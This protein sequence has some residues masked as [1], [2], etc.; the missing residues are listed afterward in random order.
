MTV[1]DSW[2]KEDIRELRI[3]FG[4]TCGEMGRHLDCDENQIQ[5]WEAG[6]TKPDPSI[7]GRLEIF[8]NQLSAYI[9]EVSTD[10]KIEVLMEQE[11][12][13]QVSLHQLDL[14]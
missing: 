13:E 2:S 5:A 14:D 7:L 10:P 9:E 12:L 11:F 3:K 4:W 6:Q 1:T 8:K